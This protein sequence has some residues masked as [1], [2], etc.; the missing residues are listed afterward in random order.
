LTASVLPRDRNLILGA[1]A[2]FVVD[3]IHLQERLDHPLADDL[4]RVRP[5]RA[6]MLVGVS[7]T[8]RQ[9]RLGGIALAGIERVARL[10]GR[11]LDSRRRCRRLRPLP[12]RR[13]RPR[14]WRS[15][16][17]PDACG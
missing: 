13:A 1:A 17:C 4:A 3:V 8:M 7:D 9:I 14:S 6:R 12:R 10:R 11:T 16:E 5:P 2:L 15:S